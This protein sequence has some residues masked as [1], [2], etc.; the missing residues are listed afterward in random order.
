ML[1][2]CWTKLT[3]YHQQQ[4]KTHKWSK[5]C[6]ANALHGKANSKQVDVN[7][8]EIGTLGY[9]NEAERIEFDECAN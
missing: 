7:K 2:T 9:W 4:K 6:E 3:D 5:L 1:P 8:M